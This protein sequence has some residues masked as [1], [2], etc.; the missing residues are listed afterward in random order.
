LTNREL[1]QLEKAHEYIS[2]ALE[3]WKRFFADDFSNQAGFY[4]ILSDIKVALEQ[5][6]EAL[7]FANQAVE[8]LEKECSPEDSR[9]IEAKKQKEGI[10]KYF[11]DRT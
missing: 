5:N 1:N 10:S 4:L 7:D 11:A 6:E 8:I 2:R 9:L 3:I